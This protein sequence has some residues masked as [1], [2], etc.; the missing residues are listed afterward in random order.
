MLG[1]FPVSTG[2]DVARAS[3]TVRSL[4]SKVSHCSRNRFRGLA[5]IE[6]QLSHVIE[7][8]N[9]PTLGIHS[10]VLVASARISVNPCF[11]CL[12]RTISPP[13][14]RGLYVANPT[15]TLNDEVWQASFR[16]FHHINFT[17]SHLFPCLSIILLR[18]V[19]LPQTDCVNAVTWLSIS[20][21]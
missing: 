21:L 17:L 5:A 13:G 16:E 9:N 3:D 20:G 11:R 8:T 10:T 18:C 14:P 1:M 6:P 2:D 15:T 12:F 19:A 7:V 4:G